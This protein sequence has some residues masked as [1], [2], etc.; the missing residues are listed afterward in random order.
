[1]ADLEKHWETV[2]KT[3]LPT[4]VSWYQPHLK[5]SLELILH[6]G[7]GKEAPIIDIGGG[8]STLV[9]DLL[10]QGFRHVT[11]LDI[12]AEAL[13]VSKARLDKA[14]SQVTWIEADVTQAVLSP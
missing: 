7:V 13:K 14:A 4:D 8:A 11:V 9:D 2:Y 5:K 1:M 3:K 12:T 6:T 10:A